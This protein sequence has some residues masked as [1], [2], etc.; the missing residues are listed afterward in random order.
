[1]K[2]NVYVLSGL[3]AD[4]RVFQKLDLSDYN[5]TFIKWILPEQNESIEKYASRLLEQI[6]S[7]KPILVGL[8]FGGIMATEI[9]KQIE[10]E[11]II[12]IS[13][14]KSKHEIPFYYHLIGSIKLHKLIP[15]KFLKK[16]NWIT[17][18]IFGTKS[19]FEKKLLKQILIDT[20]ESFL[21]WAIDKI[22]YW[23]SSTIHLNTFHIHGTS[24]KILPIA[25]VHYDHKIKQGGHFMVLNK[26]EELGSVLNK[27]I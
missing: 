19:D 14:A 22:I 2:K 13:S 27:A 26:Y 23:K 25:F 24:D 17:N 3:G 21:K 4:E 7:E 20:N 11:K 15:T 16:S 12:L 8:S 1:L 10:T 9:A 6:K 18:W 5:T